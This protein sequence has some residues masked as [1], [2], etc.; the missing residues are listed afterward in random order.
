MKKINIKLLSITFFI[1]ISGFMAESIV[2]KKFVR[3]VKKNAKEIASV[4]SDNYSD[5]SFLEKDLEGKKIIFIGE[6]S[7]YLQQFNE[8]KVRLIK[9]LTKELGF[10]VLAYESPMAELFYYN[11]TSKLYS[12]DSI[13][14]NG[15]FKMWHTR[16]NRDLINYLKQNDI[17]L[18]GFDIQVNSYSIILKYIRRELSGRVNKSILENLLK[19]D[20]AFL[21]STNPVK[22][23]KEV[24]QWNL[25]R[26]SLIKNYETLLT[27]IA[28]AK[29]RFDSVKLERVL[30]ILTIKKYLSAIYGRTYS[31]S[32]RDSLMA[33]NL[34]WIINTCYRNDKI[35]VWAHN[36]HIM[37]EYPVT[38]QMKHKIMGAELDSSIKNKS[39]FIGL[40]CYQGKVMYNNKMN[41]IKTPHKNSLEAIVHSSG[42]RYTFID[43]HSM[44]DIEEN[45]WIYN[46]IE[47]LYSGYYFK[48]RI[49]L[50]TSY[51][52][53][54]QIDNVS[55]AI[56]INY[57]K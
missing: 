20:S 57:P 47:T 23:K 45:S 3:S 11:D 17:S 10:K 27:E 4:N 16:E 56:T 24:E 25:Q 43:F 13:L 42:F 31:N 36:Y 15:I 50:S 19:K 44:P 12:S 18:V 9:Y 14:K 54:I 37:K 5:L 30:K 41:K 51:D 52:A 39:Y 34:T 40:Y 2:D 46:P 35:I 8:I 22:T 7:H 26:D 49:I 53:V 21:L 38:M 1:L 32:I 28:S 48:D 6:S 29:N 33:E 55:P